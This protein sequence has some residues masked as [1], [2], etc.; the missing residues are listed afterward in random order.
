MAPPER[1]PFTT[2]RAGAAGGSRSSWFRCRRPPHPSRR[3]EIRQYLT[4]RRQRV[5]PVASPAT[6][7]AI[8]VRPTTTAAITRKIGGISRSTAALRPCGPAR[9][10]RPRCDVQITPRT[11]PP[12]AGG[13]SSDHPHRAPLEPERTTARNHVV[14][15]SCLVVWM[16]FD[17][18]PT[19]RAQQACQVRATPRVPPS[20]DHRD[21]AA[22]LRGRNRSGALDICEKVSPPERRSQ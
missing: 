4:L 5:M 19:S 10:E 17:D 16:Q 2:S 13:A 9:T 14:A 3:H 21:P 22:P 18:A 15:A 20:K 6:H 12:A 11:P 1:S 8:S 7:T